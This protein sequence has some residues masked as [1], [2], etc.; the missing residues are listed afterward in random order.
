MKKIP[1]GTPVFRDE[2]GPYVVGKVDIGEKCPNCEVLF[3]GKYIFTDG[4]GNCARCGKPIGG[5]R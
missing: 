2:K 1:K 3:E 4:K 5:K